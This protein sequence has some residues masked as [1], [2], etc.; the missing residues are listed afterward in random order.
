[1]N[2]IASFHNGQTSLPVV[3]QSLFP[4][5]AIWQPQAWL[6]LTPCLHAIA[7]WKTLSFWFSAVY[8]SKNWCLCSALLQ[9][10]G[11]GWQC[12]HRKKWL[13]PAVSHCSRSRCCFLYGSVSAGRNFGCF[14]SLK[15]IKPELLS[16]VELLI[17]WGLNCIIFPFSCPDESLWQLYTWIIHSN[18]E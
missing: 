1:M 15:K 7:N 6:Q 16:R 4:Y 9:T 2:I 12:Q 10:T 8:T 11:E 13:L 17:I 18:I 14:A 5:L 3:G